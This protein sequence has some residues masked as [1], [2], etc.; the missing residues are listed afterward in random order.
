MLRYTTDRARPGLVPLYDIQPG[1]GAGQFLQPRSPHGAII[2]EIFTHK[3]GHFM[4]PGVQTSTHCS[5]NSTESG[6][7]H[8]FRRQFLPSTAVADREGCR[9]L[10]QSS[11]LET[12]DHHPYCHS[13]PQR[14]TADTTTFFLENVENPG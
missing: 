1:N 6:R 13:T 10:R 5:R 3:H 4:Y 2:R 12:T 14:T 11:A 7:Y 8:Y 9:S